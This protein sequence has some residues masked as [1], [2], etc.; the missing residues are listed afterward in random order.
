MLTDR[1]KQ[2]R[3]DFAISHLHWT[4]NDWTKVMFTDEGTFR[5]VRGTKK[6]VR[7]KSG[8][9][10]YINKY[11]IKTIKPKDKT[12]NAVQYIRTL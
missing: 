10:R 7:W 12:M 4:P 2:P 1:M 9:N 6:T 5:L 11:I 8:S 3:L